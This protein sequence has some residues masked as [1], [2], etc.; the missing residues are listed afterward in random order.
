MN[1]GDK[2]IFMYHDSPA[3]IRWGVGFYLFKLTEGQDQLRHHVITSNE[4]VVGAAASY[5][6]I[7]E[8]MKNDAVHHR[9][10]IFISGDS[11][12]PYS[13]SLEN[14][15]LH[16]CK[17]FN[18][19]Y[20]EYELYYSDLQK[21]CK[22]IESFETSRIRL[23]SHYYYSKV[24]YY[25]IK[26]ANIFLLPFK[27]LTFEVRSIFGMY[28]EYI[29]RVTALKRREKKRNPLIPRS[30]DE[31]KKY[32]AETT[33]LEISKDKAREALLT[34]NRAILGF[35]LA[36]ITFYGTQ[37]FF[38]RN[39]I[40]LNERITILQKENQM[41]KEDLNFNKHR[42]ID[43]QNENDMLRKKVGELSGNKGSK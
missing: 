11:I 5:E 8:Q 13:P 39:E 15:V 18:D 26:I 7:S 37:Y 41:M 10:V 27:I 40:V 16:V 14:E 2:L 20:E 32:D 24:R 42:L 38:K 23:V 28:S 21:I 33:E 22:N 6:V 3:E 31:K 12:Q 43:K 1:K 25:I 4:S 29:A 34:S 35:M 9:D 17:F 19:R 36:I 30:D